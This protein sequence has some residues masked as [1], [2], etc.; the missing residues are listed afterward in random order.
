MT[1]TSVTSAVND[2][3]RIARQSYLPWIFLETL[4]VRS[5]IL[6]HIIQEFLN[7]VSKKFLK[8]SIYK[9]VVKVFDDLIAASVTI[10]IPN[11]LL[12]SEGKMISNSVHL[13][14]TCRL[15][16]NTGALFPEILEWGYGR[17]RDWETCLPTHVDPGTSPD[18][19]RWRASCPQPSFVSKWRRS[20]RSSQSSPSLF[21]LR[22]YEIASTI[23]ATTRCES[24]LSAH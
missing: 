5:S 12:V 16:N 3:D 7:T 22:V 21:G 17:T 23:F 14:F 15:G 6:L 18:I 24:L 10:M 13:L 11:V 20:F 9:I 1:S 8:N 19:G 4:K 2:C